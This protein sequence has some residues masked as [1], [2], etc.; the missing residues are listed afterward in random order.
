MDSDVQAEGPNSG[1]IQERGDAEQSD[2]AKKKKL[3]V[4]K[5]LATDSL[6]LPS[7]VHDLCGKPEIRL[8]GVTPMRWSERFAASGKNQCHVA[9]R[10]R[11]V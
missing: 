10:I 6:E 1:R 2:M 9:P 7:M 8:P 5:K 11:L 3:L 4:L